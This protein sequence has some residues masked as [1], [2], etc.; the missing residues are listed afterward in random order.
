MI[1]MCLC[2]VAYNT[3]VIAVYSMRQ[4][5]VFVRRIVVQNRR[6][7]S[8]QDVIQTVQKLNKIHTEIK[9]NM[10]NGGWLGDFGG[11]LRP[12][13]T[14]FGGF[15]ATFIKQKTSKE[16]DPFEPVRQV[17]LIT[18]K[19]R[20]KKKSQPFIESQQTIFKISLEKM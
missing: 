16:N 8:R 4:I 19:K 18:N 7:K 3:I 2:F 15:F 20:L 9:E 13:D 11:S 14:G 6:K 1:G 12:Y 17:T 5:W 10:D